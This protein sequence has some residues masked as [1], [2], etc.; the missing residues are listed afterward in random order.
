M[1]TLSHTKDKLRSIIREIE[2]LKAAEFPHPDSR[3]ALQGVEGLFLSLRDDIDGVSAA[4]D[5]GVI[6]GLCSEVTK[7]IAINLPLLGHILRST[8]VR[9]AFEF[10]GPLVLLARKL[11][12]EK[13]KLV[14]SSEWHFSPFAYPQS[15]PH[16]RNFA[17]IGLPASESSN[18]LIIPLAGHELGHL[19]WRNGRYEQEIQ[20]TAA[21]HIV[22]ELES[23]WEECRRYIPAASSVDQLVTD[24]I[25]V[26]MW[27]PAVNWCVR[28]CQELFCDILALRIFAEGYLHAFQYILS[29][30]LGER[31]A[32]T[33]PAILNRVKY[34]EKASASF[35][36]DVPDGYAANFADEPGQWKDRG[37]IFLLSVSD[38]A[39]EKMVDG[40]I[41]DVERLC[42]EKGIRTP[43]EEKAQEVYKAFKLLIPAQRIGSV[44][45]IVNGGWMAKFDDTLWKE[46]PSVLPRREIVLNELLLKSLEVME[47]EHLMKRAG[48]C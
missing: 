48:E 25:V 12:G 10:Y 1:K 45:D 5:R 18:A 43:K 36:I 31:R 34:L 28:Q 29:P 40:I 26:T 8:N 37:T 22:D 7:Q 27:L 16:L 17:L 35:G 23:R 24:L 14:L 39:V 38:H 33:Y 19:V 2:N 42:N 13:A 3:E 9:N 46:N 6:I 15:F 47:V 30:Y 20:G 32:P 41:S 4:T 21:R 11:L 44:A